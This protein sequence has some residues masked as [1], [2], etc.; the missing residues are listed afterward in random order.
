[1]VTTAARSSCGSGGA[2]VG[3][4]SGAA[5]ASCAPWCQSKQALRI[6]L[7]GNPPYIAARG[8]AGA[9]AA[10]DAPPAHPGVLDQRLLAVLRAAGVGRLHQRQRLDV[11]HRQRPG[12]IGLVHRACRQG[13]GAGGQRGAGGGL[14]SAGW[15]SRAWPARRSCAAGSALCSAVGMQ[16]RLRTRHSSPQPSSTPRKRAP[17]QQKAQHPPQP[18]SSAAPA[19]PPSA[20]P[21]WRRGRRSGAAPPP[22]RPHP[23][24]PRPPAGGARPA[25]PWPACRP[26]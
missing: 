1:M 12:H 10:A 9:A 4:A 19:P 20:A 22:R 11:L 7:A 3:E 13:S 14:H 21:S 26:R 15:G 16:Q 8:A 6:R 2:A 5:G 17:Q 24:A 18:H 23:P 25:S